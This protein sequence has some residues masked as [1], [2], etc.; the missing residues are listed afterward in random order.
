MPQPSPSCSPSLPPKKWPRPIN[1]FAFFGSSATKTAIAQAFRNPS[2]LVQEVLVDKV[3]GACFELIVNC[4]ADHTENVPAILDKLVGLEGP[5]KSLSILATATAVRAV[6]GGFFY[7]ALTCVAAV[8]QE[9][10]H[11][12]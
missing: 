11:R 6:V 4:S 9:G 5:L 8:R 12:V 3:Y 1:S 7:G 2:L 10:H